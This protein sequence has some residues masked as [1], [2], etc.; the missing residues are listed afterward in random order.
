MTGS[1][2][3]PRAADIDEAG[4]KIGRARGPDR[5]ETGD[6]AGSAEQGH[7]FERVAPIQIDSGHGPLSNNEKITAACALALGLKPSSALLKWPAVYCDYLHGQPGFSVTTQ[8][9]CFPVDRRIEEILEIVGVVVL[10]NSV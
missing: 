7:A 3:N 1:T 2:P 4:R 6:E 9:I 10:D 5:Q 8:T